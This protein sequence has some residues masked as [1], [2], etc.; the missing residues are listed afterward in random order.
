ATPIEQISRLPIASRPVSR[1][2]AAEV[3]FDDLRAIPWVFAW[4]QTRYIVPGWYGVGCAL[5]DALRAGREGMLRRLYS[6]WPFF[7]A[8]V[9]NAQRE[10]AR[11]RLDIAE[12]YAH[13]HGGEDNEA[14]AGWHARIAAD[15]DSARAAILSISGQTDLLDGSPV[16]R[17][18][19]E[20]RNPYTD[21]LNLIQIELLR[22]YRG[23][24]AEERESLRQLLFLSINGIAAAM[25]S[26]G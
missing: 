7:T 19:I 26:T 12:K 16:I 20:L 8:V 25:Q 1:K 14:G 21:V 15:F 11:A 18:S 5:T 17:K 9:N 23:A 10:M 4:T 22:R 24:S 6:D 2:N 13:L 3:A